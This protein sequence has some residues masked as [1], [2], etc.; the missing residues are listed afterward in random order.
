MYIYLAACV[1]T[2][3]ACLRA[4]RDHLLTYLAC[5]RAYVF[6]VLSCLRLL[7]LACSRT[8][9]FDVLMYLRIRVFSVFACSTCLCAYMS[10]KL[11]SA[12]LHAWFACVLTR[13]VR[14]VVVTCARAWSA[15]VLACLACLHVFMFAYWVCLRTHISSM[16][17]ALNML[18]VFCA[19]CPCLP[20]LLYIS[21]LNSKN[22]NIE[23]IVCIVKLNMHP[24]YF[25][26]YQIKKLHFE[27]NL[28]DT[29]KSTATK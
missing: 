18:S 24:F 28:K 5:L 27:I 25:Y 17:S 29:M 21:K 19:W 26:W 1:F 2:Y 3:S 6:G 15:W 14:V 11:K 22:S 12:K 20:Y 7:Y 4:W 9:L 10:A 8:C 13:L 16:L 23:K